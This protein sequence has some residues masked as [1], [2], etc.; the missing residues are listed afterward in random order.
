LQAGLPLHDEA[1]FEGYSQIEN[2][3]GMLTSLRTELRDEAAY[4]QEEA[5]EGEPHPIREISLATGVA[6]YPFLLEE[7]R[8]I[9]AEYPWVRVRIYEIVNHFFGEQITVAGLL[10]GKD[11][12]EQLAGKDL[13]EEL[14]LPL[15]TLRAERDLFLCGMTPDALSEALGGIRL[16]FVDNDGAQLLHAILGDDAE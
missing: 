5:P 8:R 12:S 7:V 9:E 1:Y 4:L 6:A 13:G 3:V 15:A 14:L 2:G 10:T 16:R 11:L